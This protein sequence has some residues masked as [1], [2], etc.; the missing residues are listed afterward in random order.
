MSSI[1]HS[2]QFLQ[3]R[4]LALILPLFVIPVACALFWIFDGGKDASQTTRA[5]SLGVLN[6][7]IPDPI[8]IDEDMDRLNSSL[9]AKDKSEP[10]S[11]ADKKEENTDSYKE[12]PS[13]IVPSKNLKTSEDTAIGSSTGSKNSASSGEDDFGKK[14][15]AL[16]NSPNKDS[17]ATSSVNDYVPS[18]STDE[19]LDRLASIIQS[20]NN[21]KEETAEK[22][23]SENAESTSEKAIVSEKSEKNTEKVFEISAREKKLIGRLQ[24]DPAPPYQE[25]GNGQ[26][27]FYTTGSRS[28]RLPV[29]NTIPAVVHQDQTIVEGST[30]KLRLLSDVNVQGRVVP[31]DSFVYGVAK[32]SN[33][34][35]DISIPNIRYKN[36]ILPFNLAIYDQD[37]LPGIA[38]P[39][40]R[41]QDAAKNVLSQ[42][43]DGI[44]VPQVGGGFFSRPPTFSEQVTQIGVAAAVSGIKALV[45]GSLRTTKVYVK[46]NYKIY[47]KP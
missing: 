42:T 6:T 34:R 18:S 3:K 40:A 26:N 37:G 11:L 17:K 22:N 20:S 12:I 45:N 7:K 32:L 14:L 39:G 21:A 9:D 38:I 15:A 1:Q 35:L 28:L 41:A 47:L 43:V 25:G 27:R 5:S 2:Q 33:E 36:D 44:P 23:L 46:A 16:Y 4:K 19:K 13:L 24:A 31:K 8:H 29:G 30:V 10:T